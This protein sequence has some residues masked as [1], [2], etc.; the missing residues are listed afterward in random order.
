M[1]Q[2]QENR[3]QIRRASETRQLDEPTR[4]KLAGLKAYA[5]GQSRL[6]P[7]QKLKKSPLEAGP[8]SVTGKSDD[9]DQGGGIVVVRRR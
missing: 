3:A 6:K 9:K 1:V 4:R 5:R 8:A 2:R 7:R